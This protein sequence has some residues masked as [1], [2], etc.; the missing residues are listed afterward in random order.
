MYY[1]DT[2]EQVVQIINNCA[3]AILQIIYCNI[4]KYNLLLEEKKQD[5]D[6]IL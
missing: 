2:Q 4:V 5:K 1:Q 3:C 6:V